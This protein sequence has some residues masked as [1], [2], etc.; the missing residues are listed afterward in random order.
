MRC[1]WCQEI[2]IRN[3]K[4]KEIL[5]PWLI[6]QER[7]RNCEEKLQKI[8]MPHC[9]FCL[10][11]GVKS[12]CK[13]CQAWQ[14][15]YPNYSFA[16]H[17]FFK[18]D[19]AFHDWIYHYK[20]LGDFRLRKTFVPE[21]AHYF[22]QSPEA[23][24]CAIPLSKERL[25]ERGFNQSEAMLAAAQITTVDLLEKIHHTTSQAQK[26]RKE[27]LAMRQPFQATKLAANIY[28]KEVIIFD[29]VYTTGR[30]MFYAAEVLQVYKPLKIRTVSL[31]R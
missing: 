5:C 16:H 7:C 26:N 20:F 29:D 24:V 1:L 12:P 17:C 22:K 23:I 21:L 4:L 8:A 3:L 27:R 25:K 13:E 14:K 6:Q 15:L 31:A 28:G 11:E 18:Y 10:K 9:P 2:Q 30:T 19:E